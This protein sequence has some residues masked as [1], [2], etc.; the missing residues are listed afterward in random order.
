MINKLKKIS[1]Y[2]K[3]SKYTASVAESFTGGNIA[4]KFISVDGASQF[5]RQGF[6]CYSDESKINTL[7]V[8]KSIIEKY[9]AVSCQTAQ[10][11]T[12]GVY[13]LTKSDII[14]AT[15]GYAGSKIYPNKDDGLCF[16]A[17]KFK[18]ETIIEKFMFSG[19]REDNIKSGTNAA[20]DL[21][22][23]VV[24]GKNK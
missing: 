24:L 4:A 6:V 10:A 15:T 9:S 17:L 3:E 14:I 20:F 5:F 23:K 18:N 1:D 11:M 19:N 12:D 22:Y 8:N 2:I 21:I 16:I 13:A 7:S